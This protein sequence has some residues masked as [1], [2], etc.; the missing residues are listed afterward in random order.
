MAEIV[1]EEEA[2]LFSELCK[3]EHV[4]DVLEGGQD[5]FKK[6]MSTIRRFRYSAYRQMESDQ[7]NSC[8][9]LLIQVKNFRNH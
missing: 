9:P 4:C 5:A 8:N 7:A 3:K 1:Q 6:E 2:T